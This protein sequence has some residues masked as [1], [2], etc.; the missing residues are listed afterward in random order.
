MDSGVNC[1]IG[2]EPEHV[3]VRRAEPEGED[4]FNTRIHIRCCHTF[5][6]TISFCKVD[7][8]GV[9]AFFGRLTAKKVALHSVGFPVIG[10]RRNCTNMSYRM[11][12]GVFAMDGIELD[13]V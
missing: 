8:S 7:Q 4:R 9:K 2:Y 3:G 13:V 5:V 12:S 11:L 10:R 1:G 6:T